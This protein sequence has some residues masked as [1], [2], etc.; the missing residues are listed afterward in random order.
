MSYDSLQACVEDLENHGQLIRIQDEISPD[1]DLACIQRDLYSNKGPA[2]LFENVSGTPFPVLAN[3]YGTMERT[4]FIFRKSLRKVCR[5]VQAKVD[6]SSILSHPLGPLEAGLTAMT[7][8]P[9]PSLGRAPVMANETTISQLPAIKS[10]PMDGGPFITLPQVFSVEPGK[11]SPMASNLGM[12]RVQLSGNQYEKDQEIGI[13]YQIHRGI[14]VHHGKALDRGEDLKVAVFV[15]GPP[16]HCFAAIMPLPEG[17]S[18]LTFAGMM[19]ARNFRYKR[20]Q[21]HIVSSDADFCILGVIRG[22]QTKPE[23]PFGDH[24][25][26]YSL[27]HQFPVMQVEKVF[28]RDG[29]IWPFTVV[30]RP[31]QEDSN[32]GALIHKV[33]KPAVPSELPGVHAVHAVDHAG[34][35]P[36][37]FAIGSE[38]YVPYKKIV[39]QEILTIANSI[40]GFGQTSLAKY[41][42]IAAK[43]K[44][45][46]L[47]IQDEQAFLLYVLE[48]MH[49]D[50]DLHFYTK[51]TIDTLDYSGEAINQGSKLLIA[52]AGEKIRDLGTALKEPW[53]LA[54]EKQGIPISLCMPGVIAFSHASFTNHD[55]AGEE[56]RSVGEMIE[57]VMTAAERDQFP[58]WVMADDAGFVAENLA[59]F[60]WVTFTRSNPSHD[61]YGLNE[62]FHYKHWTC[63]APL[64]IDARIKP[65]HA[66]PLVEDPESRARVEALYQKAP[67]LHFLSK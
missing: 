4:E 59:N 17:L 62:H 54:F 43:Q 39:P 67:G 26:Y 47:E 60:L 56:F 5:V 13:H 9:L 53:K 27:Q 45:E 3:L 35:H 51:T 58:L 25:G 57:S 7:A 48:R 15:G 49:L 52:V 1:L 2:V 64:M 19:G 50:R 16:S 20:F 14:G 33:T 40:L 61:C 65:H 37:L 28:H 8:L 12:Y 44:D 24:L 41:L 32:F 18:E 22:K 31:P 21:G 30:G 42:L 63:Q 66:P 6:P 29:A 23:G 38:R 11:R 10:W 46:M 34:V 36:L 55:R